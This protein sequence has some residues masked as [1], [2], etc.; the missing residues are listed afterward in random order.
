MERRGFHRKLTAI[1]SADVAGY[2]RL[3]QDDEAATVE[4][5][6][7]YKLIFSNLINQHSGR[8]IDSP[9]DNLLAEF[10]SV[11][12]AV[13]CA[14]AVQNELQACNAELPDNRKMH[15]RIGVNLGDVIEE[16]DRIYGDGVN[17]AARLENIA[18]PG[19]LCIS[20]TAF[21]HIETKLPLVYEYL[22]EKPVKNIAKPVGVYR[23]ALGP[24][25]RE[26]KDGEGQLK[27]AGR[28]P[29]AYAFAAVLVLLLAGAA[30]WQFASKPGPAPVVKTDQPKTASPTSDK[31]SIAVLPFINMSG[32]PQQEPFGDGIAEDIITDLSKLAGLVVIA[33]STSSTYKG[34][35]ANVQQVGRDLGVRYLLEGSVRKAGDQMRI[36]TQLIDTSNGQ[37]LWAERYDGKMD[38]VFALQD[39]ITRKIISALALKLTASE[40][41]AVADKG[42]KNIQAYDEFL[43]GWQNYRLLTT[44]GFTEAKVHLEKAVEVDPEFCRAYAALAILYWRA[45]QF[46]GLQAGLGLTDLDSV[47]VAILKSHR[48]L[49]KAMKKPTALAYGLMSQIYLY[50]F[51]HDKALAA[52]ERAI[53]MDPNDPDLHA[54]MSNILWF[55]GENSE[56]IESAKKAQRLDPNNPALY[57]FHL[58]SAYAPDGDLKKS[59][60]L[61]EWSRMLNPELGPAAL[62][63]SIVYALQGRDEQARDTLQVFQESRAPGASLSLKVLMAGFPFADHKTSDR[64][65]T[66]L[67]KAGVPDNRADHCRLSRN[68]L[69]SGQEIGSLLT[70]RR[71]TGIEASTGEQFWFEWAKNGEL[72]FTRGAYRESGKYWVEEDILFAQFDKRYDG[73]PLGSTI[74]RNPAGTREDKNEYFILLDLGAIVPFEMV[75][76]E[77][78][79]GTKRL[80]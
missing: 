67:V 20:K 70:G 40:E 27:R 56:A 21:D 12:H 31:P 30:I 15:F 5:L 41:K 61:L 17:I 8:V 32:D 45:G 43:K 39:N 48:L 23:V 22:G 58:G 68:N 46:A 57:Q 6:Q 71:I 78:G 37:H 36:N 75:E 35:T 38:D 62:R 3:M 11:V 51:L 34:K 2:S 24:G 25:A 53:A 16:G 63:Q 80:I 10:A 4:T 65:A 44:E 47:S 50:R 33:G 9:G 76:D 29:L 55:M 60:S 14:V 64:F 79:Y 13:Q 7:S 72:K 18:E 69:L 19:G 74:F 1:L 28:K 26:K 77:L 54:W 59:L 42:T 73:L 52:I 49:K 66:A